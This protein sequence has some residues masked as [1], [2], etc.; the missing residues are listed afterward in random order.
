MRE[1][2]VIADRE[3]GKQLAFHHAL[4]IAKNTKSVV[5][6]VGFVHAAGID[7]SEILSQDDKRKLRHA[8]IGSR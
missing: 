6:F 2:L 7:S 3:D 4:E 8:Y 5:E 1:L